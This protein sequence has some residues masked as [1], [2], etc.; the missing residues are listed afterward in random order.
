MT[1]YIKTP[2]AVSCTHNGVSAAVAL[3]AYDRASRASRVAVRERVISVDNCC[4][5]DYIA[6]Y[7]GHADLRERM[8]SDGL[9]QADGLPYQ[10]YLDFGYFVAVEGIDSSEPDV[11]ITPWGMSWL[12]NRYGMTDARRVT[13]MA[14][15]AIQ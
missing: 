9:L 5:I 2:S 4:T 1:D 14:A 13:H 8:V 7:L 10:P 12:L 6:D 11:L 15:K 3:R